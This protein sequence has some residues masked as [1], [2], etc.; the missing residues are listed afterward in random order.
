MP[1]PKRPDPGS[2]T[3]ICATTFVGRMQLDVSEENGLTTTQFG[4]LAV[5]FIRSMAYWFLS[6]ALFSQPPARL[7]FKP[8][9]GS[10]VDSSS[11]PSTV[12]LKFKLTD[13]RSTI[14]EI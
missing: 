9:N 7:N 8:G 2:V 4:L 3:N 5:R 12:A 1:V 14:C 11:A 13:V 6:T 10:Q